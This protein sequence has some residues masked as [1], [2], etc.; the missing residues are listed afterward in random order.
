MKQISPSPLYVSGFFTQAGEV[1]RQNRGR[2]QRQMR[3]TMK[4]IFSHIVRRLYHLCHANRHVPP[5]CQS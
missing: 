2:D 5:R 4:H 1:G 3:R